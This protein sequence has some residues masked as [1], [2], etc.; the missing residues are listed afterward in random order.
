MTPAELSAALRDALTAA[1]AAGELTLAPDDVPAQVRVERP[2]N[3]D[4]SL[5]HI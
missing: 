2:K 1:T 3:R 5:I 4:L